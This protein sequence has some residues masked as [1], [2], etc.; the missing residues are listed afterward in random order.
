MYVH[1][2]GI[3]IDMQFDDEVGYE[4]RRRRIC[5]PLASKGK[6]VVR[7]EDVGSILVAQGNIHLEPSSHTRRL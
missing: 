5:G 3:H 4:W 2:V 7:L 1:N 6:D